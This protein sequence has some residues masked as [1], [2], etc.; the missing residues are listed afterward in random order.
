MKIK[1][2]L[3]LLA[4]VIVGLSS[5]YDDKGNYTYKDLPQI[6]IQPFNTGGIINLTMGDTLR[7]TPEFEYS[8][9]DTVMNLKY[10]W[11]LDGKEISNERNLVYK[12][13]D[14]VNAVCM[15]KVDDLDHDVFFVNSVSVS[16]GYKYEKTGYLVLAEKNGQTT[17]SFLREDYT[18]Y[19][20]SYEVD[21]LSYSVNP[22]VYFLENGEH[23]SGRPLKVHEHFCAD[24]Y[25]KGQTL[26]ITDNGIVDVN[27]LTFRKEVEGNQMFVGGW[28]SGMKA[29]NAMF[30]QWV[31]LIQDEEGHI[32]SRVKSTNQLFH[33]EYFLPEPVTYQNEVL[34]KTEV[35][36]GKFAQ[37]AMCML[38][39][40]KNKRYLMLMDFKDWNGNSS[41]GMI[42]PLAEEYASGRYPEHFVPLENLGDYNPL[43]VGYF[44]SADWFGSQIGYAMLLENA[45]R[46]YCQEFIVERDYSS[47]ELYITD[48]KISEVPEL[49]GIVN[50]NSVIYS[51]PY[52]ESGWYM[53][54]ANGKNLYLYDRQTGLV[55][56]FYTFDA[57][58]KAI[59]GEYYKSAGVG[60]GLANGQVV[61][62]K[63]IGA[64]NAVT[65]EEKVFW[66]SPEGIDL[67]DIKSIRY[68]VQAG[69]GWNP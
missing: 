3:I 23:L 11:T 68:K 67:G 38:Y 61:I 42:R 21:S 2:F 12:T 15:L 4:A 65:D 63:M 27:S 35:I 66:K 16:I 33:S 45:G 47:T 32:Y 43:Y 41:V 25:S 24:F 7:I 13:N 29:T 62:L 6:T 36:L 56:L 44:I 18:G 64:K 53:L 54:I 59:D 19:N 60:V 8:T 37:A 28:P 34:E 17:L 14:I 50:E 39:D 20:G 26:V 31:D 5:C 57:D 1:M 58:V 69:N 22:D 46:I 10:T 55:K 51:L 49:A 30:M 48:M 40:G 52:L 9:S